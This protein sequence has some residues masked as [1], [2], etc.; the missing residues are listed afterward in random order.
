MA[1]ILWWVGHLLG[2]DNGAG[3]WY[4]WWSGFGSDLGELTIL[5]ALAS[6]YWKHTCHVDRCW[7]LG[8]HPVEG[9]GYQVCRRHHP[10]GAPSHEDVLDAHAR[11]KEE[12]SP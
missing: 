9:T 2:I 1:S 3:P 8:R 4:L 5:G 12:T 11:S 7:R 6:L 10:R